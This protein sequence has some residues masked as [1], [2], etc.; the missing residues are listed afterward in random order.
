[1]I[2]PIDT[3]VF[4]RKNGVYIVG[5]S[6]RDLLCG[7]TPKDYDIVVAKDPDG[8]ARSLAARTAG[9]LIEFG[10]LRHKIL[11][12]VT[13]DY[14]FDITPLNGASIEEDLRRRDFTI[15]AMALEVSSRNL[16][17]PAGGRRD[18]AAEKV[19]MIARDVFRKDPLRLIRAYRMSASFDFSIS[20]D[21]IAA[22]SRDAD[23]I[24]RSAGERIREELFK[25]LESRESHAQLASMAH[26]GLLFGIFP[27]LLPLQS[28]R[29]RD[30]Q[31]SNLFELTLAAYDQ[32]E[33]LLYY[34]DLKLVGPA[35]RLFEEIETERA[36]LL[37]WAVLLQ[38]IGQPANKF[39]TANGTYICR[40][41]AVSSAT[42][43][44]E[45]CHKLRFSRRQSDSVEF[46]I[47]HHLEPISLFD[48]QQKK[49]PDDRA[50]I[51]FFMMCG[52]C[53]PDILLH[54]LVKFRARRT[55]DSST[56]QRFTEFI[57]DCINNYYSILQPRAS[58]PPPLNGHD[59]IR[60]FG[61][62]PS[63]ALKQILKIIIEE[64]LARQNLTRKQAFDLVKELLRGAK[65]CGEC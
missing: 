27:E 46:D 53:T 13:G 20:N 41:D 11:R 33:K 24:N 32:L 62:K 42:M 36:T 59:L 45:I 52:D 23:L 9:H 60:D 38:D 2:L 54:S 40:D 44:R 64:Q 15:N 19:C 37:K 58:K 39:I 61:L 18:L 47:R 8:F 6:I 34:Q 22:I 28:C 30:D 51:R 56:N 5:G 48:N 14:C 57:A 25:I 3:K 12:V 1:M 17:D 50:F 43:A 63:P 16:I 10:K 29:L 26:S 35:D 31:P 49:V 65:I 21:T 55:A 7:R 4:P